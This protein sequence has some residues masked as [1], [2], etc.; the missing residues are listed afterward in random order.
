MLRISCVAIV[1]W[2]AAAPTIAAAY[3][4]GDSITAPVVQII[5]GDTVRL[6]DG[7]RIVDTRLFGIDA[8]EDKQSCRN[9]IGASYNCGLAATVHLAELI[10]AV[11]E[12]CQSERMHGLC[13]RAA[14]S[15]VCQVMDLDRY[16]RVV[17][18]C[19]VGDTDIN[20]QMVVDGWARAYACYSHDYVT[21]EAI[22]RSQRR[23]QWAG[24]AEDPATVRHPGSRPSRRCHIE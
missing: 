14:R 20:R 3:R 17:A 10:G 18:R 12:P 9:A 24:T 22:A 23:G 6:R 2:L 11:T 19:T 21:V 4:P 15:V 13:V 5:D 1:V 8:P 7:S 16:S